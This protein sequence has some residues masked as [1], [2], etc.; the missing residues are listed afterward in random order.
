MRRRKRGEN[1][2]RDEAE[3]SE[4]NGDLAWEDDWGTGDGGLR[5]AQVR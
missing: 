4:A 3:R 2:R 1:L 5:R